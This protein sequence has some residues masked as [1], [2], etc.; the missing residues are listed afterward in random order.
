MAASDV[1]IVESIF[2]KLSDE[3]LD[4]DPDSF[5]PDFEFTTPPQLASEPDT[6]RGVDGVRR[7]FESFYEAMDRVSVVPTEIVDAGAGKVAIAMELQTRGRATG[8]ELTQG[9][10]MLIRLRDGKAWRFE[11]V[12]T[13]P[14]ALALAETEA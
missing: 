3:D 5:H 14:E 8:L 12:A 10:A 2:Q 13:L 11:I 6:Y 1:A 9:A 4:F 7:W